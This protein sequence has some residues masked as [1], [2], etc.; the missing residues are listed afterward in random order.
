MANKKIYTLHYRRKRE[1]KTDYKKR[2]SLLK[3]KSLRLVVRKSNKHLLA[4]LIMY[5]DK[6]DV[7]IKSVSSKHLNKFGWNLASSN[8]PAAY[9]VGLLI[10]KESK[11]KEAVLDLGLQSPK[12]G[13]KIFAVLKGAVEGGLKINYSENVLPSEERISGKHLTNKNVQETFEKTKKM[14]L[15]K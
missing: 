4:Q 5:G 6:G 13:S 9:L 11:G 8:V 14:I 3:S 10:G 7:V 12:S 2:L 15:S 1:G